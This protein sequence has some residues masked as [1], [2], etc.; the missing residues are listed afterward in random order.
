MSIKSPV[1]KTTE[2]Q[3]V[4]EGSHIARVYQLIHIGTIP[5]EWQ[6]QT[7]ERD[8]VRI[9]FEIPGEMRTFREGEPEKPMV[10]NSG[11]LTNTMNEKGKLRPLVQG[12]IGT[13][14][15]EDEAAFFELTDI[16][17]MACMI[18][19]LHEKDSKGTMRARIA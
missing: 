8:V 5:S 11:N 6:G 2:F 4:P 13:K 18:T 9:G 16:V 14:L 10:I 3:L 19:V 15:D 7:R 1:S 12:I 17:G